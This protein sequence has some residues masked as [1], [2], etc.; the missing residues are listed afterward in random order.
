MLQAEN[1]A[2]R[3]MTTEQAVQH[4]LASHHMTRYRLAKELGVSLTSVYSWADGRT[5]MS[6]IAAELFGHKY[7]ITVG[8]AHDTGRFRM[9]RNKAYN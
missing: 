2:S 6:T 7:N 9:Y 3:V 8:D 1:G 4:V 5:K